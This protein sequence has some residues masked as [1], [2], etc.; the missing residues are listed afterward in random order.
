[1]LIVQL[2]CQIATICCGD[3]SAQKELGGIIKSDW[4][5]LYVPASSYVIRV[6]IL[7][8]FEPIKSTR[9]SKKLSVSRKILLL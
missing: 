6:Y 5:D 1:M 4:S 7:Q 3:G 8:E 9:I 2:R